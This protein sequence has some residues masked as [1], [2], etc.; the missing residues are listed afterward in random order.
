[1]DVCHVIN[2]LSSGGASTVVRSIAQLDNVNDH[3]ICCLENVVE[4]NREDVSA[5]IVEL[6]ERHK[7]DPRTF[8][9]LRMILDHYQPDGVHLHLPYAQILGRTAAEV[10]DIDYVISTQHNIPQSHHPVT[11]YLEILTRSL[12]DVTVAVSDGV[13]RA[14]RNLQLNNLLQ[15]QINWHTIHNGIDVDAFHQSVASANPLDT[16]A[17]NSSDCGLTFLCVSR[18]VQQK[19]HTDLI[20]A[21]DLLTDRI[22]NAELFLVGRGPLESELRQTVKD[23]GL[24]DNITVTGYV[25]QET[26]YDYYATADAF[27]LSSVKEGFGIVLIE[28]MAAELPVIATDIPGV[29]EVVADN[30]SGQLVPTND[31]EALSEAMYSLLDDELRQK[32]AKHG[33]N[34]ARNQ[35]TVEHSVQEYQQLYRRLID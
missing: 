11:R 30:Q 15:S 35:F 12:D 10:A 6:N 18:Y 9:R 16:Q 5:P 13:Q 33:Y 25:S 19:A 22:P 23:Q 2:R 20:S 4:I 1:M 28:A 8:S 21:M 27:V 34:R 29:N 14:N 17:S 24:E 7:F 32:Y 26:L 31:P 3:I